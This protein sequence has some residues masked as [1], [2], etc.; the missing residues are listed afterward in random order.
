[1]SIPNQKPTPQKPL[2]PPPSDSQLFTPPQLTPKNP[3]RRERKNTILSTNSS[4]TTSLQSSTS[5]QSL[6]LNE[7][8]DTERT[9]ANDLKLCYEIFFKSAMKPK[10]T[11]LT[12][13]K[14]ISSTNSTGSTRNYKQYIDTG[15][16]CN[17]QAELEA[18][19]LSRKA[20]PNSPNLPTFIDGQN[21]PILANNDLRAIFLNIHALLIWS[22]E[23][24]VELEN[25]T[26]KGLNVGDLF[27]QYIQSHF[28]PLYMYYCSRQTS[29]NNRF[30]HLLQTDVRVQAWHDDCSKKL[31]GLTN[32]WDLPSLLV[33][34][35]QRILK[36]PLLL[37]NLIKCN[38]N[39]FGV[40]SLE[41]ALKDLQNLA[42]RINDAKFR[43]DSVDH[44][45]LTIG[46]SGYNSVDEVGRT[47][48][49]PN[50]NTVKK[51]P[52]M[53]SKKSRTFLRRRAK[54]VTHSSPSSSISSSPL[55]TPQNLASE[56]NQ[57]NQNGPPTYAP[58]ESIIFDRIVGQLELELQ[59]MAAF[60]KHIND[61]IGCLSLELNQLAKLVGKWYA[62]SSL[63]GVSVVEN[64]STMTIEAYARIIREVFRRPYANLVRE[65]DSK[66]HNR[67][68]Q[69]M[70]VT[71]N[72]RIVILKRNELLKEFETAL[73]AIP[74]KSRASS[75]QL[76]SNAHEVF[77]KFHALDVQL[78]IELPEFLKGL[79][80]AFRGIVEQFVRLQVEY[81]NESHTLRFQWCKQWCTFN[82]EHTPE[83]IL[84]DWQIRFGIISDRLDKLNLQI[85]PNYDLPSRRQSE[86]FNDVTLR[87]RAGSVT[88]NTRISM[89]DDYVE[90]SIETS[91]RSSGVYIDSPP[92]PSSLSHN[93]DK[94][95]TPSFYTRM[96]P[97]L[98]L[99]SYRTA[100]SKQSIDK[101]AINDDAKSIANS[102]KSFEVE[103]ERLACVMERDIGIGG[104][105]LQVQA[106]DESTIHE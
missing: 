86:T 16:Q 27:C 12:R 4:S 9:Y 59:Q 65:I 105:G 6:I 60:A 61:W 101:A 52:Q 71:S 17:Q 92:T 63:D 11:Q 20:F 22:Q 41:R 67:L 97:Q 25:T 100:F 2:P 85:A 43:K 79:R 54:S 35:F 10:Q 8:L 48:P 3:R 34:P 87:T 81:Y 94:S 36:Y 106:N 42:A 57:G 73:M 28:E 21:K 70:K 47:P 13:S 18:Y 93:N 58:E 74:S 103:T 91:N 32:A 83:R 66:I 40:N 84:K 39:K 33:K 37:N 19:E 56:H 64:E 69:V 68:K 29:S 45:L 15:F 78:R 80:K 24:L 76:V 53:P 55:Q 49:T 14:S 96:L 31:Q 88:E 44:V 95:P 38:E 46:N 75:S 7:L 89:S 50:L 99:D 98:S 26:S 90:G 51:T 62:T 104:L 30:I 102:L 77:E 23:F 82:H 72:P 5:T 1:M